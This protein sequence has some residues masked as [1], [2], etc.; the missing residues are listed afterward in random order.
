MRPPEPRG[1]Q[2]PSIRPQGPTPGPAVRCPACGH[3]LF[4]LDEP[5]WPSHA[6]AETYPAG[7]SQAGP[8]LLRVTEAAELLGIS[9]SSLYQLL[10]TG[11]LKAV[12]LGRTVRIP[13]REVDRIATMDV[14]S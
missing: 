11:R 7:A 12:R 9:R 2:A 5:A 6:A 3:A 10:A 8:L 13:R 14:G 1:L 4:T